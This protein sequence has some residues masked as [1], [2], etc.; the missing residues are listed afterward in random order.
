M[1]A[2]GGALLVARVIHYFG[3]RA[4][5]DSTGRAIGAGL[6]T[7]T[8]NQKVEFEMMEG[9]DGRTLAGELKAL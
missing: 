1:A 4:A 2:C 5:A 9:R 6:T 8:D 3:L 7:L